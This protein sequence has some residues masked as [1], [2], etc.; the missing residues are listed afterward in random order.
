MSAHDMVLR[1]FV[2]VQRAD[3]QLPFVRS[4]ANLKFMDKRIS[5]TLTNSLKTTLK[6]SRI[7]R[8][9]R[10]PAGKYLFLTGVVSPRLFSQ[11]TSPA[12]LCHPTTGTT[13]KSDK[14]T[15]IIMVVMNSSIYT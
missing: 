14:T 7:T 5:Q 4:E 3:L 11:G 6:K 10:N 8:L 15:T 13:T 9:C 12:I 1:Q 2:M